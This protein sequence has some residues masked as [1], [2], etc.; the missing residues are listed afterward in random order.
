MRE[1]I[2]QRASSSS[3]A[4]P[5]VH[6]HGNYIGYG[7]EAWELGASFSFCLW[8]VPCGPRLVR[9]RSREDR[10]GPGAGPH[11]GLPRKPQAH[12]GVQELQLDGTSEWGLSRR[13]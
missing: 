13:E 6:G 2:A 3:T 12:P 11:L 4:Q 10:D 1:T 9:F 5:C 8:H 7:P